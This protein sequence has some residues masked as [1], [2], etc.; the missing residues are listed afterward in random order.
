MG[1]SWREDIL[2]RTEDSVSSAPRG[3]CEA[4][5]ALIHCS[6]DLMIAGAGCRI[7]RGVKKGQENMG[8]FG[9]LGASPPFVGQIIWILSIWDV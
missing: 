7:R 4:I 9:E 6:C 3:L 8:T 2:R 1:E 5:S